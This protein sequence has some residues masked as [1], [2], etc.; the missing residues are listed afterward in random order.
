MHVTLI[1]YVNSIRLFVSCWLPIEPVISSLQCAHINLSELW[2]ANYKIE[3]SG[4]PL[5]ILDGGCLY[6]SRIV[7]VNC[8]I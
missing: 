3:P 8:L 5:L 6:K 2:R 4:F 1:P 7:K